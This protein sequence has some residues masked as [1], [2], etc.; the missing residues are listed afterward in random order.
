MKITALLPLIALS[1][2][3]P[4]NHTSFFDKAKA[5]PAK[6]EDNVMEFLGSDEAE[7]IKDKAEN[8]AKVLKMREIPF[9]VYRRCSRSN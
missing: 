1:A 8:G 7:K 3:L 4:T 6:L 2:A 9:I 5:L